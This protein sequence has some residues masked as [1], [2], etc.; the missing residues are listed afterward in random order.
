MYVVFLKYIF[1]ENFNTS[2]RSHQPIP[3]NFNNEILGAEGSREE[4]WHMA[5]RAKDRE[6]QIPVLMCTFYKNLIVLHHGDS[7]FFYFDICIEFT[8]ST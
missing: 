7:T 1:V 5:P 2:S 4:G 6:K 8:P 3:W